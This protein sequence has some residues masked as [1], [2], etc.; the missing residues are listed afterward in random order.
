MNFL[1]SSIDSKL[2]FF[3][4]SLRLYFQSFSQLQKASGMQLYL[5]RDSTTGVLNIFSYRTP[6]DGCFC[7]FSQFKKKMKK[8]LFFFEYKPRLH[9]Q[10]S[11]N[12]LK[13]EEIGISEVPIVSFCQIVSDSLSGTLCLQKIDGTQFMIK[14]PFFM[15]KKCSYLNNNSLSV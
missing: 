4:V 11:P 7:N 2:G 3:C 12:S 5:I 13:S 6:L 9:F 1:K 14:L 8:K 15:K 10:I